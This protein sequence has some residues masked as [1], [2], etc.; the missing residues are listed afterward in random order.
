MF[1]APPRVALERHAVFRVVWVMWCREAVEKFRAPEAL[2][3][4]DLTSTSATPAATKSLPR[5]RA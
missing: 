1:I 2:F 3:E 5:E 4:Q